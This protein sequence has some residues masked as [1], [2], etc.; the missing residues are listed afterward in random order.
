MPG[1]RTA[2]TVDG[3]PPFQNVSFQFIDS[4]ED[5]RSVSIQLPPGSTSAQ[6]E[7]IAAALQAR[8]NASL[9]NIEVKASYTSAP[10]VGNALAEVH[11]S[12]FD[13]VVVLFKDQVNHS[14]DI[15]VLA[16][17]VALQPDDSDTPVATQLTAIILSVT[18]ALEQ[19]TTDDWQAISAR[20]TERREKNQ[21]TFI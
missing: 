10:D 6:I 8:S 1:T 16:P 15:F 19:G 14:Q 18:A 7:A 20:Y 5:I 21:R 17:I 13:N 3:T 9:Y 11:I 4:T 12:V 2:P